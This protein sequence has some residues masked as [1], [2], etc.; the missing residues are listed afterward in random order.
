MINRR[1]VLTGLIAAPAVIRIPGLLMPVKP[2]REPTLL[3]RELLYDPVT[4]VVWLKHHY[5][6]RPYKDYNLNPGAFDGM[7]IGPG[8]GPVT[9]TG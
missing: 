7:A 1:F 5:G 2:L 6:W 8:V 3:Y 9:A 4:N